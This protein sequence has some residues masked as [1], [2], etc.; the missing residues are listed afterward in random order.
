[1]KRLVIRL[2]TPQDFRYMVAEVANV[3]DLEATRRCVIA[4]AAN[5]PAGSWLAPMGI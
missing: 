5:S 2:G 4:S 3:A 1:M